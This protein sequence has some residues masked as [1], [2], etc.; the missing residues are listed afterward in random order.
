MTIKEAILK[1]LEDLIIPV[2]NIEVYNHIVEKNYYE[3]LKGK[4]PS[5]TISAQLG[6]FIRLGDSR[7]K[8][9]KKTNGTYYYYLTK[10]EQQIEEYILDDES[11][12]AV[13]LKGE[14]KTKVYEERDL[15]KLLSSF[16]K[17]TETFSKTIFHEQSNGKDSNQIWTHPD[18][19]GIK[20]L[21]LQTKASQNFLKSINRVDTFKLSSYE[22]KREINSDS[23]LKKAYFQAVSN[24]SWA[25]YG[26][27]VAFEF[28]DSLNEEMSRLNQSFGIGIIELNANP[29]QSKILFPAVYRDLDFKTIDKLCK[30]NKEF[31]HFIEQ[32]EKLLTASE[33]YITGA[34]KELNEFCD[35]YF[36]SDSEIEK[37]CKDKNIPFEK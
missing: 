37:Y 17:N 4:T 13:N 10:N 34:E 35:K 22:L 31:E 6:D 11:T 19:I 33:K 14:I 30:I 9:I 7:V 15:H 1:S 3:F 24:S 5:S 29:Y 26:Y 32:T 16:L 18:M 2:Y 21:N 27:L 8:R 25:N 36:L 28:S 12:I 20:F 23:E